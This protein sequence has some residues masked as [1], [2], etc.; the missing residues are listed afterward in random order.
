MAFY[1]RARIMKKRSILIVAGL[2]CFI[3]I[4]VFIWKQTWRATYIDGHGDDERGAS[5]TAKTW[6]SLDGGARVEEITLVY[7]STENARRELERQV[8]AGG[9]VIERT[10]Y[11]EGA[12]GRVVILLEGGAAR[13]IRLQGTE[14]SQVNAGSLEYAL[15]FDRAWLKL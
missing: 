2:A 14:I 4:S 10:E 3:I 13:I 5:V 1:N 8:A 12:G 6:E 11:S 15:A 9:T 7:S